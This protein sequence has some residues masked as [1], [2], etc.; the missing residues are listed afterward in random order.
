MY[1]NSMSEFKT[2][3]MHLYFLPPSQCFAMAYVID[4]PSRRLDSYV[5]D[6]PADVS[7]RLVLSIMITPATPG[8]LEAVGTVPTC[9]KE[10]NLGEI[11]SDRN[12]D[13]CI[14]LD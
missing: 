12:V 2:I 8:W 3:H 4:T 1:L 5:I 11:N 6:T 13:S 9:R 7:R 14:H 10:M